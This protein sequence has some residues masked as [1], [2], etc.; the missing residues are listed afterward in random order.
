MEVK[1][2]IGSDAKGGASLN[3]DGGTYGVVGMWGASVDFGGKG[4]CE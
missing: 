1:P 2:S 3:V 4:F